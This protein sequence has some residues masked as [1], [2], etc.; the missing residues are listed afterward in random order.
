MTLRRV[1]AA[2][3]RERGAQAR[4]SGSAPNAPAFAP[5]PAFSTPSTLCPRQRPA[6]GPRPHPCPRPH[7][8]PRPAPAPAL[9]SAHRSRPRPRP[10]PVANGISEEVQLEMDK[11]DV[12]DD[13]TTGQQALAVRRPRVLSCVVLGTG[14]VVPFAQRW[15]PAGFPPL[16]PAIYSGKARRAAPH[17]GGCPA[18]DA[19]LGDAGNQAPAQACASGAAISNP[20]RRPSPQSRLLPA[21]RFAAP[22]PNPAPSPPSRLQ[23]RVCV[24]EHHL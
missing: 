23:P 17:T 12:P 21:R 14:D 10:R 4:C 22:P 6:L 7:P 8:R 2:R 16:V 11:G 1:A 5:A 3:L 9:T 20:W 13:I 15:S 18:S 19:A 24:E